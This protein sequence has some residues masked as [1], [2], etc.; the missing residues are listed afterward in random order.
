MGFEQQFDIGP[1][2]ERW[3]PAA[4]QPVAISLDD[5]LVVRSSHTLVADAG[6]VSHLRYKVVVRPAG[7]RRHPV[8][9][10]AARGP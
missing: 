6:D 4:Y 5:T 1:L 9:R 8:R 2:G 7:G 10:P 3:L